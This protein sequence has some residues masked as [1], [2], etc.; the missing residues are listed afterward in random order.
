VKRAR[1]GSFVGPVP[2]AWRLIAE[3][4]KTLM[5]WPEW[6]EPLALPPSARVTARRG[7]LHTAAA[8]IIEIVV[9]LGDASGIGLEGVRLRIGAWAYKHFREVT[10]TLEVEGGRSFVTIAR[11]DGRP[12]DPHIN[13]LARR[14]RSLRHLPV[15]I[16]GDH[17]H[18]FADNAVLGLPAFAPG[19]NLPI[20]API[21]GGLGSFRD[22]LRT[23][24]EEFNIDSAEKI[25]PPDWRVML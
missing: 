20:A 21:P 24:A 10:A 25:K 16:D 4:R 15:L 9:Q 3:Q 6:P 2:E 12:V 23:L 13:L 17:V 7:E 1:L 14:H 11:L 19:V 8:E 5:T 18:R 22:F